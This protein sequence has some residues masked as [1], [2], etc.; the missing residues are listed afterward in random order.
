MTLW[1]DSKDEKGKALLKAKS[2]K[3]L[4]E[5]FNMQKELETFQ[6]QFKLMQA[7][8]MKLYE[9]MFPYIPHKVI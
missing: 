5:V 7:Y 2:M 3:D 4:C 9:D 1:P 8:D 6:N